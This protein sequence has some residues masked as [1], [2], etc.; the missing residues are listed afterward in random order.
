MGDSN[1]SY[2]I[3][4]DPEEYL[5]AAGLIWSIQ[6]HFTHALEQR[7]QESGLSWISL[8]AVSGLY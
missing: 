3:D 5:S 8:H 7:E 1:I 4:C 2:G 6:D